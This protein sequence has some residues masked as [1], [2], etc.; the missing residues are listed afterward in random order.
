MYPSFQ[1]FCQRYARLCK[2][3]LRRFLEFIVLIKVNYQITHFWN[4]GREQTAKFYFLFW[5]FL[6][7]YDASQ[8]VDKNDFSLL[9]FIFYFRRWAQHWL[10]F[11]H[12]S[13]IRTARLVSCHSRARS[14]S[15]RFWELRSEDED[16]RWFRT[17]CTGTRSVSFSPWSGVERSGTIFHLLLD[18]STS[19]H[20]R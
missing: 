18:C 6:N 3:G 11:I 10:L 7:F 1:S 19:L 17:I 13:D 2:K 12:T 20:K 4:Q 16:Q 15:S 5:N 8:G 9:S 14:R